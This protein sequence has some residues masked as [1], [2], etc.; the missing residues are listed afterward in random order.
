[1]QDD[2]DFFGIYDIADKTVTNV[3]DTNIDNL[4]KEI[5]D[6]YS[7]AINLERKG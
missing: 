3:E 6:W 2:V 7:T 5:N 1:M 4:V